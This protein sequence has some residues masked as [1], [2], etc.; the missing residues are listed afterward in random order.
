MFI[1]PITVNALCSEFTIAWLKQK[2][3]AA[4]S[5]SAIV[6]PPSK[7]LEHR[8][9]V[10]KRQPVENVRRNAEKRSENKPGNPARWGISDIRSC[11]VVLSMATFDAQ[12]SLPTE[13]QSFGSNLIR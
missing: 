6:A 13:L 12:R 3:L 1:R 7:I 10:D 5:C 8:K 2:L 9:A 4:A 11:I